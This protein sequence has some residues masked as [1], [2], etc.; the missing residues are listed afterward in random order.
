MALLS[1][2]EQFIANTRDGRLRLYPRS[3]GRSARHRSRLCQFERFP[4]AGPAMSA[5]R[6]HAMKPLSEHLAQLSVQTKEIE[7]R[8]AKAQSGASD[9]IKQGREQFRQET[10][11]ALGRAKQKASDIKD[12]A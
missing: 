1:G 8:V 10:E 3:V 11:Q 2:A 12:D 4:P 6:R 7:D 5:S 9:Q